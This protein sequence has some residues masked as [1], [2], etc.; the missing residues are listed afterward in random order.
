MIKMVVGITG[1]EALKR[2]RK[3]EMSDITGDLPS[4]TP[5]DVE[6]KESGQYHKARIEFMRNKATEAQLEQRKY[7]DQIA[8]D[9]KLAVIPTRGLSA[10]KRETGYE[11]TNGWTKH[12]KRKEKPKAMKKPKMEK[13]ERVSLRKPLD[14]GSAIRGAPKPKRK[15]QRLHTSRTGKT[16]KPLRK[17]IKNGHR[18]F[19]FSDDIWKVRSPR[20][21]RR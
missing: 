8:G 15:R 19:S 5:T 4:I 13:L 16:P 10:L 20:K 11:W 18:V 9:L 12:E 14:I 7:L 1:R 17:A 3:L 6:L 2:A 21:R